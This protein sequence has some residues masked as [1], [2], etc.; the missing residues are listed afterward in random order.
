MLDTDTKRAAQS[1]CYIDVVSRI[2]IQGGIGITIWITETVHRVACARER[3]G[4]G[5]TPLRSLP[6][7]MLLSEPVRSA[8]ISPALQ[9][10]N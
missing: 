3:A 4:A 8:P 5:P 1:G 7:P 9:L 2:R 6:I 10:P